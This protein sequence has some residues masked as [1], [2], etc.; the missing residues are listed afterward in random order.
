[1]RRGRDEAVIC[2]WHERALFYG[3]GKPGGTGLNAVWRCSL[4]KSDE[5]GLT[6]DLSH[7]AN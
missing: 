6:T 3:A 1:M 4:L 2:V 5:G 7:E